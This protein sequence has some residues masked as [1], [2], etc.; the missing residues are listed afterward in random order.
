MPVLNSIIE[1]CAVRCALMILVYWIGPLARPLD[2]FDSWSH[3]AAAA[4][5][6]LQSDHL[7]NTESHDAGE[8]TVLPGIRNAILGKLM[9]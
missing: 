6:R 1:K 2:H 4:A 9:G 3:D 5:L 7:S 8:L